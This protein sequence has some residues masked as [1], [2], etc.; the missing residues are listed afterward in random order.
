MSRLARLSKDVRLCSCRWRSWAVEAL[1]LLVTISFW[2]CSK[3]GREI[4]GVQSEVVI[5]TVPVE[6]SLTPVEQR[7]EELLE[8]IERR[9][10]RPD[11]HFELGKLYQI[12]GLWDKAEYEY[13]IVLRFVPGHHEAQAALVKLLLQRGDE[14]KANQCAEMYMKQVGD[15]ARNSL[16]LGHEFQ[17][18]GLDEYAHRCYQQALQQ[19]PNSARIHKQIGYYYLSRNDKDR[20]LEYLKR[21]FQL[22]PYQPEVAGE[23]GRLGVVVKI[24]QDTQINTKRMDEPLQSPK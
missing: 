8:M 19:A 3:V 18:Q 9:F 23:L 11:A 13:N 2:G 4:S 6:V 7:K 14:T 10:E 15:S 16:V 1:A 21:S 20:A 24:P 5:A 22:D 17:K 12:D